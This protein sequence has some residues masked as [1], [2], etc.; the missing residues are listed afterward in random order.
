MSEI[1]EQVFK[2]IYWKNFIAIEDELVKINSYVALD[3]INYKTYSTAFL[4][5]ML[6]IGSEIDIVCKLLCSIRFGRTD[7]S[8]INEYGDC[9][10]ANIPDFTDVYV[11]ADGIK[12][13]PW[14]NWQ[15]ESP[16]WWK[17]YN[18]V[19]HKR[20]LMATIDGETQEFYKFANLEN[21]MKS[22]MALYQLEVYVLNH[23][24]KEEG[25]DEIFS[26][27]K[28]ALF[29]LDGGG[30]SC[31][32]FHGENDAV[33]TNNRLFFPFSITNAED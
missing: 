17:V 19:K 29:S 8:K 3:Q 32:K 33:Y 4:K 30:W 5:L 16:K 27:L 14:G 28:S 7:V 20:F 13:N 6:E 21:V 15:N 31:S 12:E 2:K 1:T 10:L 18:G 24:I 9:I 11:I 22:L 23:L 25:K 26:F